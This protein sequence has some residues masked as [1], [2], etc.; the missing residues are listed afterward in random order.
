MDIR[1]EMFPQSGPDNPFPQPVMGNLEIFSPMAYPNLPAAT[2]LEAPV[3]R[4]V[5]FAG[6]LGEQRLAGLWLAYYVLA[7]APVWLFFLHM[8]AYR[9]RVF[10]I[11]KG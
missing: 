4:T 6:V 9:L 8:L 10:R 1:I 7:L 3:Q 11:G 5:Y 2:W